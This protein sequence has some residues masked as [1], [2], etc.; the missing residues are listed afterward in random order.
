MTGI[1]DGTNKTIGMDIGTKLSLDFNMT[2][3]ISNI[4][5]PRFDHIEITDS[6]G[7]KHVLVHLTLPSLD[8]PTAETFSNYINI[9]TDEDQELDIDLQ[10]IISIQE[11]ESTASRL[12]DLKKSKILILT[13]SLPC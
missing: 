10:E 9:T 13:K 1:R 8:P 4:S 7:L 5:I 12:S 6:A 11:P 2:Y 3:E